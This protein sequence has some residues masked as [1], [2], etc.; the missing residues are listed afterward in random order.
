MPT[1]ITHLCL[2]LPCYQIDEHNILKTNEVILMK[3]GTS[4]PQRKGK[5]RGQA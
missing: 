1:P 4:G 2:A 5:K 3:I